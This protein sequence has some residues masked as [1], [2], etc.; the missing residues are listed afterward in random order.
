MRRKL[1]FGLPAAIVD[2]VEDRL[3]NRGL[4]RSSISL[5][6]LRDLITRIFRTELPAPPSATYSSAAR[7]PRPSP[8]VT[9]RPSALPTTTTSDTVT[10]L[11]GRLLA[12]DEQR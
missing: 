9:P 10:H 12:P 8:A 5:P 1:L 7:Q 3:D 6:L 2:R 11:N 4:G